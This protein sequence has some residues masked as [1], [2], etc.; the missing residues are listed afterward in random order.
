MS[1]LKCPHCGGDV[2]P[3]AGLPNERQRQR[4]DEKRDCELATRKRNREI[5]AAYGTGT[6][7]YEK[8]GLSFGLSREQVR[9]AI[10]HAEQ[11]A[12]REARYQECL[13]VAKS[14]EDMPIDI[15]DLPVRMKNRWGEY[16]GGKWRTLLVGDVSKIPD[17]KLLTSGNLGR[18]T[19]YRWK[20]CLTELAT[21]LARRRASIR[22]VK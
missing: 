11:E 20:Q 15:L 14:I 4:W 17:D 2:Y 1:K 12:E 6:T 21:E 19:L 7:T 5:A 18:A 9:I 13:S 8:L 10:V 3:D 16:E 22:L